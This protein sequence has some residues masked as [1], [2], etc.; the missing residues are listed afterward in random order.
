MPAFFPLGSKFFLLK[1]INAAVSTQRAEAFAEAKRN[2]P[3]SFLY[4]RGT[5]LR[6]VNAKGDLVL[7]EA[8]TWH[9]DG[10]LGSTVK[11]MVEAEKAGAVSLSIEGGYD[12]ADSPAAYKDGDY[13]PWV[14]EW[15]VVI[16]SKP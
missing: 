2:C 10:D 3:R 5:W 9:W 1:E 4:S 15:D 14:S 11:A 12:C 6:A 7:G 8:D 16:W 13:E